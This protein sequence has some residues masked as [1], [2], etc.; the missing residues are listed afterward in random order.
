MPRRIKLRRAIFKRQ[1]SQ[2]IF[3]ITAGFQNNANI[4]GDLKADFF[5]LMIMLVKKCVRIMVID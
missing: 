3:Q 2:M 4:V 5:D 1:P